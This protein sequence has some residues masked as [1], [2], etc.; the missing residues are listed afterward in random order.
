MEDWT[1]IGSSDFDESKKPHFAYFHSQLE[2]HA[3]A[4]K[5]R[6]A[7]RLLKAIAGHC[8][9]GLRPSAQLSLSMPMN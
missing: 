7:K 1:V 4:P 8:H 3:A 9:I 2:A 5:S 6:S